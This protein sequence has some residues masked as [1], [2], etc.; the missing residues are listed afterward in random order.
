[1][2]NRGANVN[3]ANTSGITALMSVARLGNVKAAEL[4]LAKMPNVSGLLLEAKRPLLT[5]PQ[6]HAK[7]STGKTALE[8]AAGGHSKVCVRACASFALFISF[9]S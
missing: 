6:V 3:A 7:D 8:F 4:V 5:I 9:R 2:L 1:M